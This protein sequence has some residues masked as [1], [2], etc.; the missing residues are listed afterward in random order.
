MATSQ[1]RG[2]LQ[3]LRR[4]TLAHEEAGLTDGQL[5]ER[6]VRGEEA[7]FAALVRRHGPMVWGVCRRVLD[8]PQDAEDAF[9]ATFLVLVRK[10]AS[11]VKVANWLYGV[12]HQTAL[13]ARATAARRRAR[14]K[15]VTAMPEPA[16]GEQVLWDDLQPLLDQE[17]SRLPDKYREVIVLCYLEGRTVKE[18]AGH[19][20]VPQ[21]T[22]ASRLA[23][24]RTLLARRLGRHGLAVTGAALAAE[25]SR[26]AASAGVPL[27]VVSSTIQ[28]ASLAAGSAA[29]A[30]A[31]SARAVALTEGVLK[32]MLLSKLKIATAVLAALA[33]LG[34]GTAA[35]TRQV[36][37]EKAAQ[38]KA[39]GKEADPKASEKKEGEKDVREVS[40]VVKGVNLG[41]STVTIADAVGRKT[42]AVARDAAITIDG[43][44]GELAGLQP[45]ALV[46]LGLLADQKTASSV[47]GEAPH[48]F[49][50][51]KAVDAEK[52]TV[53]VE[54]KGAEKTFTVARGARVEIDS[55]PGKLAELPPGARLI[56]RRIDP[57]TADSIQAVGRPLIGFVKAVDAEKYAI[58]VEEEGG[59][60]GTF[61]V[62]KDARIDIDAKP[63]QLAGVPPAVWVGLTLSADQKTAR[64]LDVAGPRVAGFVKAVD[65]D[66][67]TIAIA[68]TLWNPG[69][70][71]NLPANGGE[72]TF[73]VAK[74]A[75]I[76]IDGKAGTLA[77]LPPGT[78][79]GL[80]VCVDRKTVSGISAAGPA[81]SGVVK[82]VDAEKNT[83]TITDTRWNSG[84]GKDLPGDGGEET[85]PV[86]KDAGIEIDG[87]PGKLAALPAGTQVTLK[88]SVD[89]KSVRWIGAQGPGVDGVVKA[90]DAEK[91]TITIAEMR[92]LPGTGKD[93]PADGGEETFAVAKD[94]K[95]EIDGKPAKLAALST[96]TQVRLNHLSVDRK[97][98]LMISAQGPGVGGMVKAVDAGKSTITIEDR[99]G[100]KMFAVARDA[101]IQIDGKPG[102]L[103][104]LPAG[105]QVGLSLNL[106]EKTVRGITAHGPQVYGVVKGVDAADRNTIT[107]AGQEG[108]KT[109]AV[110]KDTS[111]EIDGKPGQLAGV[112]TGTRVTL[113]LTVDQKTVRG[114]TAQGPQVSGVVTA[115][116]A[117]KST[118][119]VEIGGE[120]EK[121][122]QVAKGAAVEIDGKPGKLAGLAREAP[123]TLN[124]WCVDQKTVWR[125]QA[126]AP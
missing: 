78:T 11:V 111:V 75:R 46:T 92:W 125:I 36:P 103:A 24:A 18:A 28:A 119:T 90:V 50:V 67:A 13:K 80:A 30:G 32:T 101:D 41:K 104:G 53:T 56:L 107:I 47:R 112:P 120:G 26:Q 122:F 58:T 4:A 91:S 123:V 114:I 108:E 116:D 83:I 39:S 16:A 82:A 73:A 31:L 52:S 98:V 49:G 3:T 54:D 76:E 113:G 34:A 22:V 40:G 17:L 79:V 74:D 77:G 64:R 23:T 88:L 93:L 42:V 117:E 72:E 89:R 38:Q 2:V 84:T 7:A 71:K 110:A 63:G 81:L 60:E 95:I 96:G 65:A 105:T 35:L 102:T 21:G 126:K 45:G 70:G 48:V 37:A 66:K 97:T 106:D 15:Q 20:H 87:K 69:L 100:E 8:S 55:K 19:L 43:K 27:S 62:A 61:P 14:E 5:L 94:A 109:F 25:L 9:Q 59:G 85:F 115:F 29:A 1:L 12:A 99:E 10:A 118:I 6:Y 51:A 57:N 124:L 33:V 44:P 68:D 86:A 121:T